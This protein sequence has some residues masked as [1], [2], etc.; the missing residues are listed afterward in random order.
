MVTS[1]MC[2]ARVQLK[3]S[4]NNVWCVCGGVGGWGW[5]GGGGGEFLPEHDL[6]NRPPKV[7]PFEVVCVVL[8]SSQ[9]FPTKPAFSFITC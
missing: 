5:G 4:S 8:V 9:L 6:K 3:V 2:Y 1:P 7:Q